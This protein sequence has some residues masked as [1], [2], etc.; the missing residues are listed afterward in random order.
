[1]EILKE[2]GV[3]YDDAAML[4]AKAIEATKN[5]YA[6]YSNFHVGAAILTGDGRVIQG[7]N[8]ENVSY[9]DTI[10]AER[11]AV[12]R[13]KAEGG[14]VIRAIAVHISAPNYDYYPT[15]CG[16]C[17]QVL[18]EF[19]YFPII[20]AKSEKSFIVKTVSSMLPYTFRYLTPPKNIF[21]PDPKNLTEIIDA[22]EYWLQL[23]PDAESRKEVEKWLVYDDYN[24]MRKYM[25]KRIDFGTAGLRGEMGAGYSRMNYLVV[26]QSA[27]VIFSYLNLG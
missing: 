26:Q 13:F 19:G 25:C 17:R 10:C 24:S 9:G 7:G 22:C 11:S 12:F 3:T 8:V 5:C 23:D 18:A 1:M 4:A 14:K 21:T 6:P 27:Q 20:C 15:P 16:M 2:Y